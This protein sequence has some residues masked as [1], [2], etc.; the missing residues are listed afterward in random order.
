[1]L[2][3][4]QFHLG[5][6][7][8][9]KGKP[10]RLFD[11]V[12]SKGCCNCGRKG[13]TVD[14]CRYQPLKS[15]FIGPLPRRRVLVYDKKD[16]YKSIRLKLTKLREK[17]T[18][19]NKILEKVDNCKVIDNE[20]EY[21]LCKHPKSSK[22]KKQKCKKIDN[23]TNCS[24]YNKSCKSINQKKLQKVMEQELPY[25]AS[26]SPY[27]SNWKQKAIKQR[28]DFSKWDVL[29]SLEIEKTK[30]KRKKVNNE[31]QKLK[32]QSVLLS[33]HEFS[34]SSSYN[35]NEISDNF[36]I[37]K[38]TRKRRKSRSSEDTHK[39]STSYSPFQNTHQ[40]PLRKSKK[41]YFSQSV[42]S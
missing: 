1:M 6:H 12:K 28:M 31:N 16:I 30:K 39:A 13:H 34:P 14:D 21:Q 20:N 29:P 40:T 4:L 11:F 37:T 15:H 17:K 8:T 7:Q 23:R 36:S 3:S 5:N 33:H 19:C 42:T 27:M 38:R 41:K 35:F 10:I 26:S 9:S 18:K 2:A 22:Q 32:S 24:S 25:K